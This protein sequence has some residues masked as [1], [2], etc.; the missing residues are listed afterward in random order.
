MTYVQL[1]VRRPFPFKEAG[2]GRSL[3]L[4]LTLLAMGIMMMGASK[5]CA[6]AKPPETLAPAPQG[7]SVY[8]L[9]R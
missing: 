7:I 6:D 9:S 8:A 2:V 4:V 1:E 5:G 3:K